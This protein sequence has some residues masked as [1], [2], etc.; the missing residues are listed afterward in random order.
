MPN[1]RGSHRSETDGLDEKS[2]IGLPAIRFVISQC[3]G[4]PNE[5]HLLECASTVGAHTIPLMP[6]LSLSHMRH[7]EY[8]ARS[9]TMHDSC[10][11]WASA[12]AA[13][14]RILSVQIGITANDA[15]AE[16]THTLAEHTHIPFDAGGIATH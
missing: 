3:L 15:R 5:C 1:G 11:R 2:R 16:C 9:I 6:C 7:P 13:N 10:R 14:A 12:Y 4:A 8:A